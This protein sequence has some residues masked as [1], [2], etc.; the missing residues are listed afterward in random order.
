V[1][2]YATVTDLAGWI[3]EPL[4]DDAPGLLRSASLLVAQAVNDNPYTDTVE[5]TDAKRDATCAQVAAWLATGV[6][7]GTAGM[8]DPGSPSI[9]AESMGDTRFEYDTAADD[10]TPQL[11]Q[12]VADLLCPEARA[13]LQTAGVLWLPV[14]QYSTSTPGWD[15]WD[16]PGWAD[17]NR[18]DWW[19]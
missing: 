13:I 16:W 15:G 5:I 11:R 18:P 1:I 3:S 12:Q 4:P 9:K 6:R 2:V 7:P 19:R 10:S 17:W 14:P 8:R